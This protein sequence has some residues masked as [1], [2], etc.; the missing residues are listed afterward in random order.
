LQPQAGA[1]PNSGELGWLEVCIPQRHQVFMAR[2]EL[3]QIGD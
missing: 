1:F 3:S 2:R